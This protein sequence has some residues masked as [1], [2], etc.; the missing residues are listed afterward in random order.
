MK[1]KV[2][3]SEGELLAWQWTQEIAADVCPA[4]LDLFEEIVEEHYAGPKP[5][6][7]SPVAFGGSD[8]VAVSAAVFATVSAVIQKVAPKLFEAA[9]DVGKDTLRDKLKEKRARTDPAAKAAPTA[10]PAAEAEALQVR[11]MVVAAAKDQRLSPATA[12]AVANAVL[13]RL[14][15]FRSQSRG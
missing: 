10:T 8:L 9:L 2:R 4:E 14:L 5:K 13:V 3:V 1:N 12:E 6:A 7:Y 11:K 15:Q